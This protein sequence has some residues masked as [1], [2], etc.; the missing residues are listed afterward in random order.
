M[1]QTWFLRRALRRTMP[2]V[3]LPIRLRFLRL[4]G[5]SKPSL[6]H[7]RFI[8]RALTCQRSLCSRS[9]TYRRPRRGF[10]TASVRIRVTSM[11]R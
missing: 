9:I 2:L 4:C 7:S 8:S 5:T 10:S 3:P 6:R 11:S 1:P